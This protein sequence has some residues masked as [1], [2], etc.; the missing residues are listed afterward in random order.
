MVTIRVNTRLFP[1]SDEDFLYRAAHITLDALGGKDV[2]MTISLEG[3]D[4]IQKLN[5]QF[6]NIDEPTDVLSF[7]SGDIDPE[8]GEIYLGDVVI[9]VPKVRKQA[10]QAGHRFSEE[11]ALMVVHGILH[12][13]GYDHDTKKAE[14]EMFSLQNEI[15]S[16]IR[17]SALPVKSESIISSFKYAVMGIL[18][19][20]RSE[21]N[22]WI[23]LAA[24]ILVL[25]CG[26]IFRIS[27]LE[28][29]LVIFSI[30]LVIT[31]EMVNTTM[32]YLVNVIKEERSESVRRIKD[33]SAAAVLIAALAAVTIGGIVFLPKFLGLR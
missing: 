18:S 28:W 2:G 8:T 16:K 33:I 32:E 27:H 3:N 17:I 31:T 29:G 14:Q 11:L 30:A 24:A 7:S 9:A 26:F 13:H 19:A 1:H 10:R 21:R 20:F 5:R 6:R 23:H 15:L 22:M 12:L 25:I 4:Q